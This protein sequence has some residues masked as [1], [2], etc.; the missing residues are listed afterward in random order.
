VGPRG[1][2]TPSE[3]RTPRGRSALDRLLVLL[4]LW[5]FACTQPILSVLGDEPSFFIFRQTSRI[6]AILFAVGLAVGPPLVLVGINALVDRIDRRFGRAVHLA[7]VGGLAALAFHVILRRIGLVNAVAS[8]LVALGLGLAFTLAYRSVKVV[9]TW[10]R[11]TAV[12]PALAVPTFLFLAPASQVFA[13]T[14]SDSEQ[15]EASDEP[16]VVFLVLDEFPTKS[17]LDDEDQIDPVR[18]PNLAAFAEDSTWYRR[19]STVADATRQAV[20]AILSGLIPSG[21]EAIMEN[22]PD[23]LFTLLRTTHQMRVSESRTWLCGFEGC[24]GGVTEAA[25]LTRQLGTMVKGAGGVWRDQV[26]PGPWEE[27]KLDDFEEDLVSPEGAAKPSNVNAPVV[28]APERFVDFLDTIEPTDD[29]TLWYQHLLMPHQPWHVYPDGEEYAND[30]EPRWEGPNDAWWRALQEQQHLFQ[31]QY[32]DRLIGELLDR[33]KD[34]GLYDDSL[35]VIVADHGISFNEGSGPRLYN[36]AGADGIAYPPLLIKAPGQDEGEIDD[37]VIRSYD[38][39]PTIAGL[40]DTDLPWTPDGFPAGSPEIAARGSERIIYDF[41]PIDDPRPREMET[42]DDTVHHPTAA[43]RWIRSVGADEPPLMGLLSVAASATWIGDD[44]DS[45][46]S[47]VDGTATVRGLSAIE[48]PATRPRPGFITGTVEGHS[49]PGRI[50]VAVN[51]VVVTAS[52]A[53]EDDGGIAF[54]AMLPPGLASLDDIDIRLAWVPKR[55]GQ[56]ATDMVELEVER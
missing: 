35:I 4:G 29:P 12:L 50:L 36:E 31:A 41:G 23:N 10:A 30:E 37:Q 5:G 51:G 11:Y 55:I 8:V 22:H 3:P 21:E 27:A 16:S 19:H 14:S 40:L 45:L 54:R 32:A 48:D 33:V 17:L 56:D 25:S 26:L 53:M 28:S 2:S 39:L 20:P 49:G 44:L 6:A 24:R 52:P 47:T 38:I 43:N 1:D 15:L 42:F 46:T 7:M 18:F 34:A 13:S 9:G